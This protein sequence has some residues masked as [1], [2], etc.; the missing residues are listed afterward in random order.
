MTARPS[1]IEVPNAATDGISCVEWSPVANFVVA[2]SWDNQI[3][4]WEV[5]AN[6]A[7]VPKAATSHDGPVLCASWCALSLL[8]CTYLNFNHIIPSDQGP[9]VDNLHESQNAAPAAFA[10]QRTLVNTLPMEIAWCCAGATMG[11]AFSR[12]AAIRLQKCGTWLRVKQ[13]R[14][15]R[16]MRQSKT[17]SGCKR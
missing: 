14:W 4:C 5:Q 16:M 13:R 9:L 2:G 15:R 12:A 1:D 11:R 10:C 3:R 17:Y 6:G 8:Y 7:S